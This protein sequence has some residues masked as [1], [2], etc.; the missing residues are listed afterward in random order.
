MRDEYLQQQINNK[1]NIGHSVH[2][3]GLVGD[4]TPQ[5]SLAQ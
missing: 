2:G 1:V 5:A 3:P 4:L